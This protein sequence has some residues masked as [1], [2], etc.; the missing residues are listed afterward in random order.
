LKNG[1]RRDHGVEHHVHLVGNDPV[2]R[3]AEVDLVE[4]VVFLEDDFAAIGLDH[5]AGIDVQRVRPD[6]VGARQ[7]EPLPPFL[8]SQE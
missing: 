1:P 3:G 8:I 6:I 4:R 7:R 5:L 2:H